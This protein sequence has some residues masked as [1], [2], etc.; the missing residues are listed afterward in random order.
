MKKAWIFVCLLA[1]PGCSIYQKQIPLGEHTTGKLAVEGVID[2]ISYDVELGEAIQTTDVHPDDSGFLN[3]ET[4]TDVSSALDLGFRFGLHYTQYYRKL[5]LKAGLD[6]RFNL[7]TS[8]GGYRTGIYDTEQQSS[9]TRPPGSGSFVYTKLQCGYF[10]PIPFL[11]LQYRGS[12]WLLELD[13]GL[14]YGHFKAESGHDRFGD[15]EKV[16]RETWTGWGQWYQARIGLITQKDRA[17]VLGVYME[18]YEA[19]FLEEPADISAVGFTFCF[20]G[21]FW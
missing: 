17:Y 13:A 2:G 19:E 4:T 8:G 12:R 16:Q 20:Q 7:Y 5:G 14:P 1:L 3:G 21:K 15:W 11:G 18:E 6:A 9:D 10:T